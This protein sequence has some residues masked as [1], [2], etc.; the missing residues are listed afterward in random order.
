MRPVEINNFQK[1]DK[2]RIKISAG[3]E[4]PHNTFEIVQVRPLEQQTTVSFVSEK[5]KRRP[6]VIVI[7]TK[8]QG[9]GCGQF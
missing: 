5:A 2:V 7:F 8:H 4:L 1:W 3:F 6:H 9:F